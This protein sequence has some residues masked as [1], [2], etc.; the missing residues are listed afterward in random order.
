MNF[1]EHQDR[2]RRSSK[3]LVILF[4][5]AVLGIVGTVNLATWGILRIVGPTQSFYQDARPVFE[6][7]RNYP[8]RL[9]QTEPIWSDPK[10]HLIVTGAVLAVILLG[11]LYK[12]AML[13]SG[14]HAIAQSLGGRLVMSDTTDN[15]ERM[16]LNVVE[17]MSIA[18]GLPV[19][20]VYILDE[21]ESINAF[22]AGYRPE[23]AVVGVTRG[24]V[25]KLNRDELQ[26]V[27]GHEFSHILNGD[28]RLNIRLIALLHG[29]LV[30][31]LIGYLIIRMVPYG[32]S[33]SRRSKD[34]G[35]AIILLLLAGAA[36]FVIGWV[37][38]FF[39]R[40]IQAA[41]SRQREFLADASS[42]QFT[43]NPQ[44]LIGALRKLGA[45]SQGSKIQHAQSMELAHLFFGNVGGMSFAKWLATHP[46]LE[47][48][49]RA[50][51]PN[52][53][54]R[55]V[56][57][58]VSDDQFRAAP[59][60]AMPGMGQVAAMGFGLQP[61]PLPPLPMA[62][63]Q[64]VQRA[65]Q[66]RPEHIFYAAAMLESI[67]SRIDRAARDPFS[68]RSILFG[69]LIEDVPEV[70][71]KQIAILEGSVDSTCLK[72]TLDLLDP[73]HH[74]GPGTRLTLLELSMP[75][76]R[77]MSGSQVEQFKAVLKSLIEADG[78][79]TLFE[80][81]LYKI[82]RKELR[83]PDQAVP[84]APIRYFALKPILGEA[85]T[86]L[87]ALARVDGKPA[88]RIEQ[89]FAAGAQRLGWQAP[90]P[91]GSAPPTFKDLDGALE[92]LAA[93]A[94][95]VKRRIIEAAGACVAA[96]GTV[97]VQEA[98]L[99][100]AVAATLDVPIPPFLPMPAARGD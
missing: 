84:K 78:R 23:Q 40:L 19:P 100:R 71:Q 82:V 69:L 98:E 22:A 97:G 38:V 37:G 31:S 36:L 33:S 13:G 10:I 26:G 64:V 95:P 44:G 66:P 11:S 29:I 85:V 30:I 48:R 27:I 4:T 73:I 63:E 42:V 67:P 28:M 45:L 7:H 1:F 34:G 86:L 93:S 46:P 55:F 83:P 43:R 90:L 79:V 8:G 62:A 16:L 91:P 39:G 61:P 41:V 65:A 72:E 59:R 56:P 52:F 12:A 49:I 9:T 5:L 35:N 18:S 6:E 87:S 81:A 2:A 53:D 68:A 24:C 15:A 57:V 21:E 70:R 76:L 75:A 51:D 77:R 47:D 88:G 58:P 54:G 3:R 74:L 32:R 89:D 25:D 99:L 17:E 92:K 50:L 80:Y 60:T 20:A 96:D 14:G 94:P